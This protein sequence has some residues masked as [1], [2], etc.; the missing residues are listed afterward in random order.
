MIVCTHFTDTAFV[1]CTVLLY[2]CVKFYILYIE[3]VG[4]KIKFTI[5]CN[6][7]CD[8]ENNYKDDIKILNE[9]EII[10]IKT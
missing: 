7:S 2:C 3:L 5:I 10:Y 9:P 1:D 6:I 8:S 4:L